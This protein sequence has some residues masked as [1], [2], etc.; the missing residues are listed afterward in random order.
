MDL[1]EQLR[2]RSA[3]SE[4]AST[5]RDHHLYSASKWSAE[6]LNGMKPL[7]EEQKFALYQKKGQSKVNGESLH[8]YL[9][10][11]T[12]ECELQRFYDMDKLTLASSYF[13][14][15]EFDRCSS[16][17][18]GCKSDTATFLRLY[19]M[20][21]SGERKRDLDSGAVLSENNG[22]SQNPYLSEISK[23]L[24][25]LTEAGSG[26]LT[27]PFLLYLAGVVAT[28]SKDIPRARELLYQSLTLYPF[29]WGCWKELL[30]S[31]G[32]FSDA[33][34]FLLRFARNSRFTENKCYRVMLLF[35]EITIHQEFFQ[36]SPE[37]VNDLQ[38]LEEIFPKF[39]F[40]KVQQA[41]V[42]YN[43]LDYA[44]AE[45]IFDSVLVLD[46]LRLDDMDTYSNILYVMEKKSKLSFLAQ[47]TLK[48]DPLRSETCCVV[49]NYYSLKFDHQKAIMYYKRAL[50]LN[51]RCLSAW[52]LMGHEFVELK[53]SHAA[54]ESYRR[55]VDANNKD[56]RAWYGLGQAYEVLD[57]NLYSLYYYQRACALRP[58]DKRMWQAIGN[59]SEKLNEYEDAIKAYKK[60]LSVSPEVDPVIMYKLASLYEEKGDVKNV[61]F[62]MLQ[63][64]KEEE[65]EGATDETS[66]ARLWLAKHEMQVK[67]WQHAYNY[68]SELMHGTSHDIEEARAIAR[69]AGERLREQNE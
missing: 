48:V 37:V 50:A 16:A 55:A 58:M 51:K 18:K 46:P 64:L 33:S 43:A 6:A 4:S 67:N 45:N 30:S 1:T 31:L 27:D 29:N 32:N 22:N 34:A 28:C 53:N 19:S 69:E 54:I 68:A 5:L 12:P 66:K 14:C 8:T 15:K 42:S 13:D 63:C 3:L 41:L 26:R 2:L 47:H 61:K 56:F 62:Y 60:A 40:V 9:P 49:A 24:K 38:F 44:A 39:S 25:Q 35:F 20:Y 23:Q 17:L 21:L 11:I 36:T 65:Y 52:T 59:C 7:S 57:M 10:K